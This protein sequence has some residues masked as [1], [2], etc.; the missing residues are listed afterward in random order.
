MH[1]CSA[2]DQSSLLRDLLQA[3]NTRLTCS[4]DYFFTFVT[5]GVTMLFTACSAARHATLQARA[6]AL[7][8]AHA[9][10]HT[11]TYALTH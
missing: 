9:H 7:L 4:S 2:S 3:I 6:R 8:H 10:T 1:L 5:D 11:R